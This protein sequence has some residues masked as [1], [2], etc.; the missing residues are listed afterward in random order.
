MILIRRDAAVLEV[1]GCQL[2]QGVSQHGVGAFGHVP[3]I[4][5][6][7]CRKILVH[8]TSRYY[9]EVVVGEFERFRRLRR[10][11]VMLA[12]DGHRRWMTVL[13]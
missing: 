3:V 4:V 7:G 1:F 6:M 5:V 11:E 2:H 13:G 8:V 12:S 9:L 10:C